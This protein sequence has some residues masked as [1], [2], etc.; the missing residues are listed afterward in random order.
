MRALSNATQTG[1]TIFWALSALDYVRHTGDYAWLRRM[2][3]QIRKATAFCLR[4][5]K[6]SASLAEL[7]RARDTGSAATGSGGCV[8]N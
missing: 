3:P 6:P 7:R 5:L 1:P 4:T 8:Y 2:M